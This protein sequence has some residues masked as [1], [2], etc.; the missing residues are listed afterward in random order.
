[1]ALPVLR[2]L[3]DTQ[4]LE[5]LQ[6]K[7]FSRD[8]VRGRKCP[9]CPARMLEYRLMTGNPP[10]AIDVC[11]HC[12]FTW[13]D[14]GELEALPAAAG[15]TTNRSSLSV[16]EPEAA[17]RIEAR[18]RSYMRDSAGSVEQLNW[19]ERLLGALGFP[20]QM[21][22]VPVTPSVLVAIACMLLGTLWA[23][24]SGSADSQV[25]LQWGFRGADPFRHF[26]ST[27]ILS[28]FLHSGFLHFL[29]NAFFLVLAGR[30][31]EQQYGDRT[32]WLLLTGGH[33]FGLFGDVLS[34]SAR[35]L[36]GASAGISA[37]LV[38]Y[39]L[40]NPAHRISLVI[41]G[42]YLERQFLIRVPVYIMLLLWVAV[43]VFMVVYDDGAGIAY[44]A[45]VLGACFGLGLYISRRILAR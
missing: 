25:L 14:A 5:E 24:D 39:G 38:F 4:F 33:V 31:V 6:S 21:G 15:A 45:H 36:V 41:T 17:F 35:V 32:L 27:W 2:R 13:F 3:L 16:V 22:T 26:G 12:H 43:Q 1:M 23:F 8:H 42:E 11:P 18:L 34:L 40:T 10:P 29:S 28:F 9:I 44:D 19:F 7:R 37:V 20:I 30:H